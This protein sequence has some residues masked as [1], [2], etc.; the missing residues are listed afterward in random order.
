MACGWRCSLM[1]Q[2]RVGL[3][4]LIRRLMQ[5]LAG[6]DEFDFSMPDEPPPQFAA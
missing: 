2:W 4:G 1:P 3:P 6:S 5:V